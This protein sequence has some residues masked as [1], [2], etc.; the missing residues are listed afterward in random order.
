M[1]SA[2]LGAELGAAKEERMAPIC[3]Q[4]TPD[5]ALI[6]LVSSAVNRRVASSSLARGAKSFFFNDLIFL[7]LRLL[8]N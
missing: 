2:M 7:K 8:V 5:R 6:F 3:G 1:P 4:A